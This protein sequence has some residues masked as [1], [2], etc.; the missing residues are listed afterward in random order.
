MLKFILDIRLILMT[1]K[2][3]CMKESTEGFTKEK[4]EQISENSKKEN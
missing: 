3:M 1:V 4:S 2:I